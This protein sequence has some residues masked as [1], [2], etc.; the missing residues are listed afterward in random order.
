MQAAATQAWLGLGQIIQMQA[1]CHTGR[2]TRPPAPDS[3]ITATQPRTSRHGPRQVTLATHTCGPF[4]FVWQT[5]LQS[6]NPYPNPTPN[7]E[8]TQLQS[9]NDILEQ[10]A[11]LL[12]SAGL[13]PS[14][15]V[16]Q[17][18]APAA[19]PSALPAA[20]LRTAAGQAVS[21][22]PPPSMD[23]GAPPLPMGAPPGM[24]GAGM[25]G[26]GMGGG[27]G[28]GGMQG[29]GMGGMGGAPMPMGPPPGFDGGGG[30]MGG[31]GGPPM[32]MGPPPGY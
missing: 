31:M 30:G 17:Q 9:T 32:P 19:A 6:T 7:R 3:Q 26:G 22:A 1:R 13:T 24:G 20:E 4:P 28:G 15:I 16:S 27:M 18:P 21:L 5:Q 11:S 29:G 14:S 8:Q 12:A 2:A 25:G 23:F 10:Q